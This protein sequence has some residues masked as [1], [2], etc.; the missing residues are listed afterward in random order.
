MAN[1][2]LSVFKEK[3]RNIPIASGIK[4]LFR[5][6]FDS[7]LIPTNIDSDGKT[8]TDNIILDGNTNIGDPGDESGFLHLNGVDFT[9]T[10]KVNAFGNTIK[11]ELILHRHSL[12][13]TSN[14]VFSRSLSGNS[15]HGNVVDGTQL[16]S[17]VSAGWHTSS[18]WWGSQFYTAVDGTPSTSSMPTK[19]VVQVTPSGSVVPQTA[20]TIRADKTAEFI[21][22]IQIT[23]RSSD[24]DDPSEGNTIIWMS[25]GTG[26]GDDGDLMLKITAGGSTKTITL[27]DFS[28]A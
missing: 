12:T 5:D 4:K 16:S 9:A 26:S 22:P 3:L 24:P 28:A 27:V 19:W 14:L 2:T 6:L 17:I 21:G 20:L 7:T 13:D 23:E 8:F 18:Y 25:D 15:S 1:T 10:T 11:A